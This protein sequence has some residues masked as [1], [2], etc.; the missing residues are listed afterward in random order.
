MSLIVLAAAAALLTPP[1]HHR[2]HVDPW[3]VT[4][5][6]T[7]LPNF[8][9]EAL[10]DDGITGIYDP[11]SGFMYFEGGD[12]GDHIQVVTRD[13][14]EMA[15]EGYDVPNFEPLYGRHNG[16]EDMLTGRLTLTTTRGVK[17]GDDPDQLV[18]LV[19]KP[20]KIEVQG[21]RSQFRVYHYERHDDDQSRSFDEDY[22]FKA[23]KLIEITL[24]SYDDA[25]A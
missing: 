22:T 25:P 24:E 20:H 10:E 8:D 2:H 13:R 7:G 19:G 5:T 1:K 12:C 11:R 16:T 4:D 23:N 17:I 9:S 3:W 18:A 6:F 21:S 14:Y 15:E